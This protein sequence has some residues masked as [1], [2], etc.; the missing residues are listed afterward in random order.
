MGP[1]IRSAALAVARRRLSEVHAT[2]GPEGSKPETVVQALS[3]KEAARR[4][5]EQQVREELTRHLQE[6]LDVERQ[7][8]YVEGHASGLAQGR[9]DAA[10]ELAQER[11]KLL[12]QA[13]GAFAAL[14]QAH[15][16][17][18]TKLESSVGEVA[19][20]AVCRLLSR[21]LS[22]RS[23]VVGIVEQTCSLLRKET[24]ATARL[25][26]RDIGVLRSL[27]AGEALQVQ[28]VKVDLVP[29][30]SLRLG[31]CVVECPSGRFDGG[32]ESQLRRL[33]AVLVAPD[34]G[35]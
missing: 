33:H 24:F 22:S 9:A 10:A 4:E 15:E 6:A 7:R 18:L 23:L 21:E 11:E 8:A 25:H 13:R 14:E 17:V 2:D 5:I 27:M 12:L 35:R 19:F 31:G 32:L 34:Q 20:A 26:P 16:G 3:V 30:E 1:L 28:G 29:D